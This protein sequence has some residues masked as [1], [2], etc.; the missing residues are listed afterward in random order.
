M[1]AFISSCIKANKEIYLYINQ[2][3]K[4]EDF[5]YHG[6]I[7]AGGDKTLN[8]DLEA[9]SVFIKH[10]SCFGN[11]YSE[12]SGLIK[13]KNKNHK[14]NKIII[15]PLDGSDNF[16]SNLPYYG[17]AVAY[18]F[19]GKVSVGV[20]CNLVNGLITVRDENNILYT[21]DLDGN[22]V[23]NE[24]L[25]HGKSK[26]GIFERSYAYPVIC[27]KLY[28][29][30]LKYRSSGAVAL[31]LSWARYY[32]FVL[33]CGNIREFDIKAA[34]Y[35]CNDLHIYQTKKILLVSKNKDIFC[36]LKNLLNNN[37]L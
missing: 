11:I 17:T 30:K 29:E 34:L 15:D 28:E 22:I 10:L 37:R 13:S 27:Q 5:F 26:L 20:V 4:P 35:I 25:S 6:E 3:L 14:N 31:S 19:D 9:E 23:N 16:L 8:I 18:E 7:G 36:K 24:I 33:F 21:Y 12:E 32:D 2:N 1:F